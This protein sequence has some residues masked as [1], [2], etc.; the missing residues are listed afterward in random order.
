[1]TPPARILVGSRVRWFAAISGALPQ[2]DE[3]PPR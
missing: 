3:S 1:M 2:F